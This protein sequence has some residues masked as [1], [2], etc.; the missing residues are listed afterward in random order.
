MNYQ[1]Y[2]QKNFKSLDGKWIA[3]TGSTG[4]L[5]GEIAS[6]VAGL[7]GNLILLDR[8]AKK[9]EDHAEKLRELY[10]IEVKT[11]NVDMS[12]LK[13]VKAM[14][15]KLK[16]EKVDVVVLNAGAYSLPRQK[17]DSGYDVVYQ[18]NFISPY[19]IVK[20]MLNNLR[21][22]KG[23]VVVVGSIAHK[24][25]QI[26][27]EDIDFSSEKAPRKVYG[28]AKR[29][30]M[31]S[32]ERL[33]QNENDVAY[34]I[35]H[36]GITPTNITSHYSK[37]IQAIVKYPMKMIFSSPK[38]ASLSILKGIFEDCS[39]NTWIGPR[40]F[41]IWGKPSIKNLKTCKEDEKDEIFKI[42]EKVYKELKV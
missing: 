25:S 19:Y 8:N 21:E 24:Y 40:Y 38:K 32:L 37:F 6:F 13:S 27:E 20:E 36:P 17:G 5:G 28:N 30:L 7:G 26:K 14:C 10:K 18:I 34:S 22:N 41:N 12:D 1:K 4:G 15:E 11:I 9:S 31:F 16:L 2:L 39:F 23:K 42:A 29:F 35:A 3:L 33:L